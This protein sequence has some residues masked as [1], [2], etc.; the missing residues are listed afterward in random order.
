MLSANISFNKFYNKSFK[1]LLIKYTGKIISAVTTLKKGYIDEIY[2]ETLNKI[3]KA[4][5]DKKI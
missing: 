3:R 4:I 1:L 2:E 5:I